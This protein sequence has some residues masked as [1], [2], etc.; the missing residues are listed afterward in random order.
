M[1]TFVALSYLTFGISLSFGDPLTP[2]Q[3]QSFVE[4]YRDWTLMRKEFPDRQNVK[5]IFVDLDH[6]GKQ[7]ALATY[8]GNF[9]EVGW[10]WNAFRHTSEGWKAIRGKNLDTG[11][12]DPSSSIFAR[13]GEIFR[14]EDNENNTQYV[15]LNLNYDKLAPDGLGPINKSIFYLNGEG[16]L[17]QEKVGNLERLLAYRGARTAGI[18]TSLE[19]LRVEEFPEAASARNQ[20]QNK[21]Q[22]PTDG[23]AKPDKPKE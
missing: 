14:L 7:E 6:D 23:A 8:Y 12:I 4:F 3:K 9:Y 2:Q 5:A 11:A 17:Q 22:H 20:E 13:P 21:A 10:S 18:V 16:V 19:A 1:K 15:V